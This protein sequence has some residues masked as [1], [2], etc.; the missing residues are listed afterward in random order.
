MHISFFKYRIVDFYLHDFVVVGI[1][2]AAYVES[3]WK[4]NFNLVTDFFSK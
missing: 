2:I 1:K 4:I 3:P